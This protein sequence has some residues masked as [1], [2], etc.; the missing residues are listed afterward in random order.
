VTARLPLLTAAI[1]GLLAAGACLDPLVSDEV[2][3]LGLVLP[4]GSE[5]PDA[6]DDPIV[7]GQIAEHDG[8]D[9]VIPLLA[10]FADGAPVAYWDFGPAT[11]AAAPVFMLVQRTAGGDLEA[12]DH[13][14][15]VATIPGDNHYSPYWTVWLVEVTDAY[16][17]EVI[18]SAAAIEEAQELGLVL[19]PAEQSFAVNCP[20]VAAGV[21]L[22]VD[23]TTTLPPPQRFYWQ[24]QTVRYYDFGPRP[25]ADGVTAIA[26]P[27][28]LLRR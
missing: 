3:P 1:A 4:A 13:N 25:L 20:A 12:V 27:M 5:V 18:P 8:V 9:A 11:L 28:Y 14:T 19:A 26:A 6:H 2:A 10:A 17:G 7:D 21:T 22:E 15:I 24:G 16:A 23:D